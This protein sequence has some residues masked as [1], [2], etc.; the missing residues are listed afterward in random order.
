MTPGK[1]AAPPGKAFCASGK[2]TVPAG[3]A[4]NGT[5]RPHDEPES[6]RAEWG[7]AGKGRETYAPAIKPLCRGEKGGHTTNFG[8]L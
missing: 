2:A 5:E 1:A 6:P 4:V 7:A 8:H 3:K